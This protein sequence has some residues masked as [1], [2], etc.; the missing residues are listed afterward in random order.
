MAD[1]AHDGA[2]P[3]KTLVLTPEIVDELNA[4][5][6]FWQ[7]QSARPLVTYALLM[8]IAACGLLALLIAP[9]E[10]TVGLALL[11]AKVN[12]FI[13]QGQLWRLATPLFLHGGLLHL[14]LN[15]Y[16]LYLM[17]RMLE[18]ILGR[19]AYLA[20]FTVSGVTSIGA[21]YLGNDA[22]SVGASGAIFGLLG[23]GV[24]FGLRHRDE[25]PR[26]F[27][28]YYGAGLLPW[29]AL[30]LVLGFTLPNIDNYAHLGGLVSGIVLARLLDP[31]PKTSA[32]RPLRRLLT[33][34]LAAASFVLLLAALG[35]IARQALSP[36]A[37][38]IPD[39]W[40][41]EERPKLGLTIELPAY[42]K[43]ESHLPSLETTQRWIEPHTGFFVGLSRP[44]RTAMTMPELEKLLAMPGT[45]S[46]YGASL[47]RI[48][49]ARLGGHPARCASLS[50]KKTKNAPAL[51]FELWLAPGPFGLTLLECGAPK[52]LFPLYLPLCQAIAARLI[53]HSE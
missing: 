44:Q 10:E 41:S 17:G 11:G 14:L 6:R 31:S 20:I 50:A 13:E 40:Q 18:N 42:L 16:A 2:R 3:Q 30:N 37:L 22:L 52:L 24:V 46:E 45:F 15:A 32:K 23:A 43:P 7:R 12:F 33:T 25:I 38:P 36:A 4:T 28:R 35:Q 8:A 53:V 47:E 48:R 39:A 21:S 19:A 34:L 9:E 29:V 1:T 27:Q 49:P 51:A 26:A 5:R